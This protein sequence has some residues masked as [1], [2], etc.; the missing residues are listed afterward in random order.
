MA[1]PVTAATTTPPDATAVPA[2]ITAGKKGERPDDGAFAIVEI[3]LRTVNNTWRLLAVFQLLDT[4]VAMAKL[5]LDRMFACQKAKRVV[6][7]TRLLQS[8]DR[9]IKLG[10]IMENGRR[11]DRLRPRNIHVGE[12]GL[13]TDCA[14]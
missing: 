1:V 3:S 8:L 14:V 2:A 12:T 6:L 13:A 7:E 4:L 5:L 10:S 9:S 11:L